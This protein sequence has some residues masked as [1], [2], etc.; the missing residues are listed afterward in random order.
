MA[1][2]SALISSVPFTIASWDVD[3]HN[4]VTTSALGR[5]MQ[6]AAEVNAAG[7]G[8]GFA[9]L[10]AEGQT[11]ILSGLL[12]QVARYP[13]F[14]D[15]I[16]LETWPRDLVNRQ[17]LRDV[18]FRDA[19]G[20]VFATATTAWYCLDLASRRPVRAD[21]WRTVDWLAD[22]RATDR[23]P[24]R[25]PGTG[26]E[27]IG[28]VEAPIRWSDLD[29]NG[30]VTNTRYQ[31]LLLES[32]PESWLRKRA[33]AE[34]ELNFL[35]ETAYPDTMRCRRVADPELANTWHHSLVRASDGREAAR[36]RIVWR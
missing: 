15:R 3:A 27:P 32:Y 8:A 35:A 30:H 12:L 31:D 9:D 4:R 33:I 23:D 2:R 21:R 10:L 19:A 22:D 13:R 7:L 34:L 20:E 6:E 17:A 1:D 24:G 11:W 28:E 25:L 29:L 36:A 14:T 26:D 18:R 5:Y 16:T